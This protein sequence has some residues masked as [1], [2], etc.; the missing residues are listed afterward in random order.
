MSDIV[1]KYKGVTKGTMNA[2]GTGTINT[3]GHYCDADYVVEYNKPN[4]TV[5][6]PYN[7]VNFYDYDG[8]IVYSYSATE[9][10][11]LSALPAS[12]THDGLT[13]QG[14]NWTLADAKAQVAVSGCLDIGQMYKTSDGKTRLYIRILGNLAMNLRLYIGQ[15]V[16]R[17][18]TID[19]GDGSATETISGT[20]TKSANHTYSTI[21]DYVIALTVTSGT[22]KLG[23]T[24]TSAQVITLTESAD[25]NTRACR[26]VL[27]GIAVGDDCEYNTYALYNEH[28]IEFAIV[29][30]TSGFMNNSYY[31][32]NLKHITLPSGYDYA[33]ARVCSALQS[34]SVPKSVA[35]FG[36]SCFDGCA[37]LQRVVFPNGITSL[38]NNALYGCAGIV[39]LVIPSSVASIGAGAFRNCDGLMEIHFKPTTPPTLGDGT[40]FQTVPTTC[41]IYVPTGYLSAYTSANNYPSSSTY[42]YVEE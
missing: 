36:A 35:T 16:G 42:T 32:R 10:A 15:T 25:G 19:W 38:P 3:S 33:Y 14:W 21:G 13:A 11:N 22:M 30:T 18:V 40:V 39:R 20:G 5:E 17:G 9:F 2:S 27:R 26:S 24:A 8:A 1:F 4:G 41:K 6:A 28:F 12:P 7:D 23:G 37:A 31:C 29:S 34:I